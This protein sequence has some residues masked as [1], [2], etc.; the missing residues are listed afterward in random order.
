MTSV[1]PHPAKAVDAGSFSRIHV[2]GACRTRTD[3][4]QIP[5]KRLPATRVMDGMS[6]VAVAKVILDQPEIVVPIRESEAAGMPQHMRMDRRQSGSL[7]G[8][9]DQVI[10]RLTGER[11]A[12]LGYE[13]PGEAVR[14]GCQIALDRAEFIARDRLFDGQ[15]VLETPSPEACL[16]EVVVAAQ[17]DRLADAQARVALVAEARRQKP[18]PSDAADLRASDRY[19]RFETDMNARLPLD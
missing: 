6:G 12:A 2:G 15:P 8:G 4:L 11:L 9:R 18:D 3:Q 13:E 17:A 7:R 14:P 10:D 5:S 1:L 19:G 16:I